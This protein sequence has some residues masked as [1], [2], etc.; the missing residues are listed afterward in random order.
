MHTSA[1]RMH[2]FESCSWVLPPPISNCVTGWDNEWHISASNHSALVSVAIRP[3]VPPSPVGRHIHLI[4]DTTETIVNCR[5]RASFVREAAVEEDEIAVGYNRCHLTALIY[6]LAWHLMS[7]VCTLPWTLMSKSPMRNCALASRQLEVSTRTVWWA[8]RPR[9]RQTTA[10]SN[11]HG[12]LQVTLSNALLCLDTVCANM[13]MADLSLTGI[14]VWTNRD[15]SSAGD[16]Y[17]RKQW[18]TSLLV[19]RVV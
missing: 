4:P 10:D 13:E 7:S 14:T 5:R 11:H 19:I 6:L 18:L 1:I 17:C 15:R 3:S 16:C 9:E 12:L 8:A 2:I